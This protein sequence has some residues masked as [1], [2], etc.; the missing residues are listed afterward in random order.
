MGFKKP[1][2]GLAEY[3]ASLT[4]G[5]ACAPKKMFGCQVFFVN[6]NMWTGVYED[7]VMLRLP[8]EKLKQIMDENDEA[9]PFT[10]LGRTMKEYAY[11]TEP[12]LN[13][14]EF[15]QKWL[16]ISYEYVSAMEPKAE[17]PKK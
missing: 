13:D 9:G 2:I 4:R 16:E 3:H 15:M 17:K 5:Y 6:N 10:P 1:T 8:Q 11:I 12:L 7:G 14:R